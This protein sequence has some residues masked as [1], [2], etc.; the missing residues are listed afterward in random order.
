MPNITI[1]SVVLSSP[2]Y[3]L[4]QRKSRIIS[5]SRC[6]SFSKVQMMFMK[7]SFV[8]TNGFYEPLFVYSGLA[9]KNAKNYLAE[10]VASWVSLN[11]RWSI[12]LT[13][14]VSSY[15]CSSF[16]GTSYHSFNAF[17]SDYLASITSR[18]RYATILS[19]VWMQAKA[20]WI[21]YFST[22]SSW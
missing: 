17:S 22:L 16:L 8:M 1:N 13:L 9:S 3:Y 14:K 15:S 19:C 4:N 12:H 11:R 10:V 7:Y 18:S 2:F 6:W 21:I 20:E 5:F